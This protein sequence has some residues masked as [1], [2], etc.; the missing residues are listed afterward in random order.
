MS[1]DLKLAERKDDAKLPL[2]LPQQDSSPHAI[3]ARKKQ[4][5]NSQT[6][7]NGLAKTR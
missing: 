6:E 2:I 5:F 1:P 3:L 7:Q 4:I